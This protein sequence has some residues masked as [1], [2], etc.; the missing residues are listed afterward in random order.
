[1]ATQ[2]QLTVQALDGFLAQLFTDLGTEPVD[3]PALLALMDTYDQ[4]V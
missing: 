3:G 4:G 1:M 2:N